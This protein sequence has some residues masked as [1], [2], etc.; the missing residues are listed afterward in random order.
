[1]SGIL[2]LTWRYLGFNKV[3]AI[4]LLVCLTITIFLPL[5]LHQII[6]HYEDELGAR[7]RQ[8]PLIIGAKGDRFDLVLSSL[9]FNGE[10]PEAITAHDLDELR[11]YGR[12]ELIP[13]FLGY[14]A[15]NKPVVGTTTD[16][17]QFRNLTPSSGT[18]P[19]QLGDVVLGAK[20][21]TDLGLTTGGHLLSDEASLI[22]I[23]G[24]YPLK[25]S[26][27]GVLAA[28]GSPDDDAVFTD[29][30]TTWIIAG[31]GHG[32]TDLDNPDASGF[33]AERDGQSIT[34]NPAVFSY[35]EITPDNIESF[36]FHSSRAELP[37]SSIIAIPNSDKDR[38]LLTA[39]YSVAE[40]TQLL[41]PTLIIEELMGIVFQVKRFF[42]GSFL[43]VL[44]AT[45]LFLTLVI[46]L[47]LRIRRRERQTMF[48]IGCDR[49]TIFWL[50]V[51]ELLILLTLASVFALVLSQ[52]TLVK[53]AH[54]LG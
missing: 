23:G 46:L 54:L 52:I 16:Y 33:V 27:V 53:L 5:A 22:Y 9:Y 20:A 6:R 39:R 43:L 13:L 37:I 3:K 49:S 4:I 48:Q 31:I 45:I 10:A 42:D 11:E 14:S 38:T 8:T 35:N 51:T 18:L 12:A 17:F 47:S 21:A 50:Q 29:I 40:K 32:H 2:R 30:K 44:V 15:Q 36:H 41:V 1:M 28:S 19:L 25:M 34:A 7:A 26:I 24:S